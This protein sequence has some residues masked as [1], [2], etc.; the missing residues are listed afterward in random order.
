MRRQ[1]VGVEG[2]RSPRIDLV[3][4]QLAATLNRIA[5]RGVVPDRAVTEA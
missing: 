2:A 5:E 3:V 1:L 4:R